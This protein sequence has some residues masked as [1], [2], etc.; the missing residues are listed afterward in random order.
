MIVNCTTLNFNDLISDFNDNSIYFDLKYYSKTENIK[1]F[2]DGSLMLLYQGTKA[3]NIWT[4]IDPDIKIM[5]KAL[6]EKKG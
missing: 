5:E 1:N 3:F 4:G 2:I 6:F